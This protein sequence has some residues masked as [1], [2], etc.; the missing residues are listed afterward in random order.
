MEVGRHLDKAETEGVRAVAE[1]LRCLGQLD[2]ATEMYRKL[3]EERS[4]VV[5]HVE[6]RHWTEAFALVDRHSEYSDLVYVP[7]AQWLA[8]NDKFIEAQKGKLMP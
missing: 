6:A 4:I 8:E 1:Y 3:G 7:Y 2:Y 5:L